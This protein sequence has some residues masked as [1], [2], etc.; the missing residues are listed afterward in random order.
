MY[1]DRVTAA[2]DDLALLSEGGLFVDIVGI[3]VEIL[4]VLRHDQPL[5]NPPQR[6]L[7]EES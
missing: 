5:S 3:G 2:A 6:Q 1:V 7:K 4:H